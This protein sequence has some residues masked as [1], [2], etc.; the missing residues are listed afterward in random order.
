MIPAIWNGAVVALRTESRER[1]RVTRRLRRAR[2]EGA[3]RA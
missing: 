1:R 3:R 2:R